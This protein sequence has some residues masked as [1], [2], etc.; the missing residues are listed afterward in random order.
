MGEELSNPHNLRSGCSVLI[1]HH[2]VSFKTAPASGPLPVIFHPDGGGGG[3]AAGGGASLGAEPSG[4][5]R[6]HLGGC[7]LCLPRDL[8][9]SG[10]MPRAP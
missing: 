8:A 5:Q 4:G 3:G 10:H 2:H 6:S 9:A 1:Q 7:L